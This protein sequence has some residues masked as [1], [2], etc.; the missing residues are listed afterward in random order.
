MQRLWSVT[1]DFRA[2]ICHKGANQHNQTNVKGSLKY[3]K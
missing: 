3:R 2:L 1:F